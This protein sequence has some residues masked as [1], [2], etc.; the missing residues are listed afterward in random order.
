MDNHK[1]LGLWRIIIFGGF[2]CDSIVSSRRSKKELFVPTVNR[3]SPFRSERGFY[4]AGKSEL[5][6]AVQRK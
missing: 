2:M 4:L 3:K 5:L 1:K 6:K